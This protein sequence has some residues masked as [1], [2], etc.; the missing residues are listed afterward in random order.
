MAQS[1]RGLV[2]KAA[3]RVLASRVAGQFGELSEST[4]LL[5]SVVAH[6]SRG[7]TADH[8][9]VR[10]PAEGVAGRTPIV[11]FFFLLRGLL[12]PQLV[13]QLLFFGLLHLFYFVEHPS[14]LDQLA[15]ALV[16][17]EV[18][19]QLGDLLTHATAALN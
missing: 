2:A 19:A 16:M 5:V 6:V 13:V 15:V 14:D 11:T 17:V 18:V 9:V 10:G 3:V 8:V 7:G 12:S 4:P 1:T